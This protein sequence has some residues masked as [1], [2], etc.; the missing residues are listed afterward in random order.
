MSVQGGVNKVGQL[1]VEYFMYAHIESP[2]LRLSYELF[3]M[4]WMISCCIAIMLHITNQF[5]LSTNISLSNSKYI[6]ARQLLSSRNSQDCQLCLSTWT[7]D[8]RLCRSGATCRL[9]PPISDPEFPELI[10]SIFN[11][12]Y[13]L[14][15]YPFL[16]ASCLSL[17]CSRPA[18]HVCLIFRKLPGLRTYSTTLSAPAA[19]WAWCPR[20]SHLC[21]RVVV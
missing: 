20:W 14:I 9:D 7:S 11:C 21:S 1:W 3:H 12:K 10:Y 6:C 13:Y 8:V 16:L 17:L 2:L 15:L 18:N 5:I 4:H 19:L